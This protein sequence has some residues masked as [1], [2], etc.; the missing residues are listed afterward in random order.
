[1]I[2]DLRISR[3]SSLKHVFES[4]FTESCKH[5]MP[6]AM[7]TSHVSGLSQSKLESCTLSQPNGLHK[8]RDFF[9]LYMCMMCSN[10]SATLLRV[11]WSGALPEQNGTTLS[12]GFYD[13]TGRVK[14]G[15]GCQTVAVNLSLKLAA[16]FASHYCSVYLDWLKQSPSSSTVHS[17]VH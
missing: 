14:W 3:I 17:A 16:L 9:F 4:N 10:C 6:C 8:Y 5:Q 2:C 12:S 11:F 1:M 15:G 13:G 7:T